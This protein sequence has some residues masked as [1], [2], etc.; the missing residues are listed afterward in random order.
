MNWLRD[1]FRR[2]RERNWDDQYF[3]SEDPSQR[4]D[5]RT[6]LRRLWEDPSKLLISALLWLF[7]TICGALILRALGL[8]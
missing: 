3:P 5:G 2:W 4:R 7:G 6:R 8:V 1:T